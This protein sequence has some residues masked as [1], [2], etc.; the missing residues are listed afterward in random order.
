M[1]KKKRNTETPLGMLGYLTDIWVW[2]LKR[3]TIT[4][5]KQKPRMAIDMR[6][7]PQKKANVKPVRGGS[8]EIIGLPDMALK[9]F[10][11]R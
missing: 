7:R 9:R 6:T 10:W 8:F 1:K 11:M 4:T 2:P 5:A 3:A